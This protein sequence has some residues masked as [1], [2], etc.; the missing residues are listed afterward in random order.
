MTLEKLTGNENARTAIWDILSALQEKKA[1]P[2][3]MESPDESDVTAILAAL[4]MKTP[5]AI[6]RKDGEVII[7]ARITASLLPLICDIPA[8]YPDIPFQEWL[9]RL[10]LNLRRI[11]IY[12]T[13][14]LKDDGYLELI[15][16]EPHRKRESHG[17]EHVARFQLM[18]LAP[19]SRNGITRSNLKDR[20]GSVYLEPFIIQD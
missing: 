14:I 17:I 11:F 4:M 1:L 19:E 16:I 7:N 2:E 5:E 15:L 9:E 18:D 10:A 20:T 3:T 12:N 8:S 13:L 6:S